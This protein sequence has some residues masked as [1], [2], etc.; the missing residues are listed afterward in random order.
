MFSTPPAV[1]VL[2]LLWTC[3]SGGV[4][5][6]R[7]AS[8]TIP[9]NEDGSD[10]T[11]AILEAFDECGT[12]G[13]IIFQ[14][15]TYHIDR[16]MTTTG[17][18]NTDIDIYGTL[19]WSENTS[20]WLSHSQWT[21]FQNGSAAWFLGGTNVTVNGHGH[22]TLD[23]N[24]QA[25]YDLVNGESNYPKRPHALAV[26]E[27]SNMTFKD[28]RMVQSQMWTMAI[29]WSSNVLFDGVYIN[30]TSDSHA[31][32][33]NT[34]GADTSNSDDIT[35]RNMYIRNGD[36]AIALKANSTNILIEDSTFDNSLGIAFGSLAQY[37]GVWERVENVTAR[38]N[39]F[40][41]TRY[42][43]YV[44][45]WTGDQVDYPPNGGGG[46]IGSLEDFTF[47][48]LESY[49]FYITQC[50]TFSGTTG[51]CDSSLFEILNV[52]LNGWNGDT[53]SS[54]KAWMDCSAASGGCTNITMSG[55]DLTNTETGDNVVK[56]RCD[57]VAGTNGFDCD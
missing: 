21:G 40:W 47:S 54:Y 8:C 35:F 29:M 49:P 55:I 25:W 16:I 52:V 33:R 3:F 42:G 34:D 57:H 1:I 38:K 20:Y 45:T 44:K 6:N 43:S 37:D 19:L 7:R 11:L 41:G 24:G 48:E 4:E 53:N 22:G 51:D 39:T 18:S 32:A 50:T 17:L 13:H 10:D 28:L 30:S 26:W 56:I 14:N 23:G 9:A 46:G 15:T 2:L 27:A 12:N 31:P 5:L 36:D